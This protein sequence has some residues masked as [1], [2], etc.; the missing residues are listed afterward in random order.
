MYACMGVV[1]SPS[2]MAKIILQKM[3]SNNCEEKNVEQCLIAT[4]S[5]R[6]GY[7]QRRGCLSGRVSITQGT[8]TK[9]PALK[10]DSFAF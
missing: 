2:R 4:G 9:T 3:Q 1:L 10:T 6:R 5:G 8:G 7:V